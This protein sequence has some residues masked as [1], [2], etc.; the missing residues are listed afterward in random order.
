M[1]YIKNEI[2]ARLVEESPLLHKEGL[3][4]EEWKN[5]AL[6][7]DVLKWIYDNL[8]GGSTTLETG[9]GYSTIVFALKSQSHLVVSPTESEH[10]RIYGL[11]AGKQSQNFRERILPSIL[12]E[13]S[14]GDHREQQ[15][16]KGPGYDA[17][18]WRPR[19][20]FS[21]YRLVLFSG[22]G[23]RGRVFSG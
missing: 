11:D 2:L 18:R 4:R 9:C 20:S 22:H 5:Y 12:S 3:G 21:L 19:L 7:G 15:A 1:G 8:G 14:T 13:G 17:D 16:G 23:K 6:S 10:R